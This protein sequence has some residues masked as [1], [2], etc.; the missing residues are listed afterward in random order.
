[1]PALHATDMLT[2]RGQLGEQQSRIGHR[3]APC[4][5]SRRLKISP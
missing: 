4:S 1:M 2:Q 5:I 3:G